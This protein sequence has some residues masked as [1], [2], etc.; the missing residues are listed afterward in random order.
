MLNRFLGEVWVNESGWRRLLPLTP[1]DQWLRGLDMLNATR[2]PNV[3]DQLL[4]QVEAAQST[5]MNVEHETATG[6]QHIRIACSGFVSAS[7]RW[8]R[9]LPQ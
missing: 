3:L 4:V 7:A 6:D 1:R 8:R 9:H 5:E 2:R